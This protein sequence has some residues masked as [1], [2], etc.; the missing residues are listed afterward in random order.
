MTAIKIG[1]KVP[2]GDLPIGAE[3][4]TSPGFRHVKIAGDRK[5]EFA[6]NTGRSLN[7]PGFECSWEAWW[8]VTLVGFHP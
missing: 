7:S 1:D 5:N 4:E 2:V 8:P 6:L 3:F